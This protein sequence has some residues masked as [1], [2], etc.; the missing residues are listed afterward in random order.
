MPMKTARE[1]KL[2]L[3]MHDV[4][5]AQ[6]AREIGVTRSM[7]SQVACLKKRSPRV[8]AALAK[9]LGQS[10]E[11]LFG[12]RRRRSVHASTVTQIPKAG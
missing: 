2:L 3:V 5:L 1:I 9:R 4:N 7:V 11:Q 12:A 10:A 8:E 6:V